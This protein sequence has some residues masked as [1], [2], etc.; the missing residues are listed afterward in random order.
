MNDLIQFQPQLPGNMRRQLS[1]Q[2]HRMDYIAQVTMQALNEQS[3]IYSYSM[4]KVIT[5]MN[6]IVALKNAFPSN[7]TAPETEAA[8]QGLTRDYLHVMEL[9]PQQAA[10]RI[11]QALQQASPPPDD[12]GLLGALTDAFIEYVAGRR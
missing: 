1:L 11:L 9:I 6:A 12:A 7:T 2:N 10:Q 5:T 3:D 8:L 4:F